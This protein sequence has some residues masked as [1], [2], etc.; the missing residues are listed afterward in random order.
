MVHK[1]VLKRKLYIKNKAYFTY[2]FDIK[3]DKTKFIL[4][5]PNKLKNI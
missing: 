5:N 4:L 2:K 1:H 3:I